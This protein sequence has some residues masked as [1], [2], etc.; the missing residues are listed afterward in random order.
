MPAV[1]PVLRGDD[2]VISRYHL[3]Q[4]SAWWPEP[5]RFDPERF[6]PTQVAARPRYTYIPFGGIS[7]HQCPGSHFALS[8]VMLI[9]VP[10]AQ[11]FRI[12]L[13]PGQKLDLTRFKLRARIRL[14]M[15]LH[16]RS[17][18]PSLV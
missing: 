10:I 9:L 1:D 11:R 4:H 7:P 2:V 6:T 15:S 17:L 12:K 8:E 18:W 14:R 5:E 16:K 3:H 13:A